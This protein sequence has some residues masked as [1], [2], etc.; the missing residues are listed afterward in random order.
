MRSVVQRVKRASVTV[1][2]ETVGRISAGLLVLLAVGKDDEESDISW[3]VN[4]L[5]GLRI[6]EDAEG[7]MNRSVQDVGGERNG[8]SRTVVVAKI[9][10]QYAGQ[11]CGNLQRFAGT[12]QFSHASRSQL[13]PFCG[14]SRHHH[15]TRFRRCHRRRLDRIENSSAQNDSYHPPGTMCR[16]RI[17][18]Q[19]CQPTF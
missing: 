3:M 16:E 4:K 15:P 14:G 10:S 19:Y 11:P 1:K 13:Q 17:G 7:R 18:P 6:F 5:V 2:E 9:S 12:Q 8:P